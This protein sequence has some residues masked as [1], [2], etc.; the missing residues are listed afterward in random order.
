MS[1]EITLQEVI[2][3]INNM[4]YTTLA[5]K[6]NKTF[7]TYYTKFKENFLKELNSSN[8]NDVK[9]QLVMTTYSTMLQMFNT[10]LNQIE[11][12]YLLTLSVK[13]IISDM[14]VN[15]PDT[16]NQSV[17]FSYDYINKIANGIELSMD[18]KVIEFL[19]N[20]KQGLNDE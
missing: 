5:E 7:N 16:T 17:S 10:G 9:V 1:E 3:E 15:L 18:T 2:D 4:D 11:Y 13:D 14:N 6:A 20:I 12:A 19:E 8:S